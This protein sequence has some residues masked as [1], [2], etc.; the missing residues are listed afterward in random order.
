MGLKEDTRSDLTQ[1][2]VDGRFNEI[3]IFDK[4]EAEVLA[5][6]KDNLFPNFLKSE[7]YLCAA[8]GEEYSSSSLSA[9]GADGGGGGGSGS[10]EKASLEAGES[11]GSKTQQ[12]INVGAIIDPITGE[13]IPFTG[14]LSPSP[15]L[16]SS[17]SVQQALLP[18]QLQT[19][20]EDKELS[21]SSEMQTSSSKFKLTRE[22]LLAT[23]SSRAVVASA[24]SKIRKSETAVVPG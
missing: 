21:T 23:Q 14:E 7:I 24:A 8:N 5:H 16:S 17:A 10:S 1:A 3:H 19:V 2:I 9:S 22:A 12:S 6:M 13:S 11:S 15:P 4:P 20:H 18:N